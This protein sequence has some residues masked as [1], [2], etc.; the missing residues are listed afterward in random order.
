MS[1]IDTIEGRMGGVAIAVGSSVS[2]YTYKV[3]ITIE[4][5]VGWIAD[6][7]EKNRS[8]RELAMLSDHQL[9]DIGISRADALREAGRSY[10]Y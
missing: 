6:A 8:R 7:A 1:T 3:L 2:A 9:D 5:I 10:W 4:A